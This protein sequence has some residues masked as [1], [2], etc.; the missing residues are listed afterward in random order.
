MKA[1]FVA[2][3]IASSFLL[4][5]ADTRSYEVQ[6]TVEILSPEF[7]E[8]VEIC[9]YETFSRGVRSVT[10]IRSCAW[11]C[12]FMVLYLLRGAIEG[13]NILG[14]VSRIPRRPNNTAVEILREGSV[15]LRCSVVQYTM[16]VR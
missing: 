2:L 13:L 15:L 12:A 6:E 11:S 16:R 7:A 8:E 1:H 14:R 4:N 9:G 3:L 10:E 5:I